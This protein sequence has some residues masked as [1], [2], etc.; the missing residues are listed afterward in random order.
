MLVIKWK[1]RY[2]TRVESSICGTDGVTYLNEC[3]MR[4]AA[5]NKGQYVVVGSRGPC[6]LCQNVHCKYGARCEN[7]QCVCPVNC[8]DNYEPVCVTDGTTYPNECEMRREACIRSQD[9]SVL[10]YGECGDVRSSGQGK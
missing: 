2:N 5:C 1:L 9:L 4:V 8:P 6:D 10:F 3:E 7:G